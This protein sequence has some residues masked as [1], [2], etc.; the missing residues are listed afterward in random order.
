M[1]KI[2]KRQDL[3]SNANKLSFS[4][5]IIL[6]V[7]GFLM[8]PPAFLDAMINNTFRSVA[9][10]FFYLSFFIAVIASIK[11]TGIIFKRETTILNYFALGLSVSIILFFV[12]VT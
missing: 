1:V 7:S 12:F 4:A 6:V 5:F 3:N 10:I 8:A 9:S 11:L 2:M